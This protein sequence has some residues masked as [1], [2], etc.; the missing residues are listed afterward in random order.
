MSPQD[1]AP[2][3]TVAPE[4][5]LPGALDAINTAFSADTV[6]RSCAIPNRFRTCCAVHTASKRPSR[7]SGRQRVTIL[8]VPLPKTDHQIAIRFV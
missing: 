7:C 4:K 3:A 5:K 8:G 1:G 6:C 2:A